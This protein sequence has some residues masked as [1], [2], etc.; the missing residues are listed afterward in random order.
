MKRLL[1]SI[2]ALLCVAAAWRAGHLHGERASGP[3][4]SECYVWQR[5]WDEAVVTAVAGLPE[6]FAGVA[7]LCAE[8]SWN[9]AGQSSVARPALDFG[10]LRASR[11]PVSAVLRIGPWEPSQDAQ[12]I[13]C[14]VAREIVLHMRSAD[15]E[16]SELQVDFD[17]AA[18]RLGAYR[19][20]L[21]A[22]REAVRPLPVHPTV[23]PS[24][25]D[26]REFAALAQ[27]SGAFI[28]Q[29]HATEKPRASAPET[30]LCE[31]ASARK[32]TEKAGQLGVPFRVA[33]PTYTYRV[34]FDPAGAL[35]AIEAEG[36]PRAWP[37]GTVV[38]AFRPDAAQMARLV[39]DW[40]RD[41]PAT[42]TGLIWY[43][44]PVSTDTMNWRSQTLAAVMQGRAPASDLRVKKSGAQPTDITLVNDGE[45]EENYP[46]RIVA[47]C[48]GDIEAAD[49]VGGYRAEI[50]GDAVVFERLKEAASSTLAP[51]RQHPIGWVHAKSEIQLSIL[52]Q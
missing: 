51:G 6:S 23:L 33:L 21:A 10:A 22:L 26:H 28:L 47:K 50:S 3:L 41:R 46:E 48:A 42:L 16:P 14:A 35:L 1:I 40:K 18:S 43:R 13:V 52:R 32:W 12:A 5:A 4:R 38:R 34:A 30:A 39:D 20:W 19:T 17:C 36:Q 44:L 11:R 2:A 15:V 7:P 45:A 25:L 8:I 24:W 9:A 27:E 49:G 31:V 37:W 29:V